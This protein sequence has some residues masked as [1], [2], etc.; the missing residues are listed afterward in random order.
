MFFTLRELFLYLLQSEV[1]QKRTHKEHIET[2]NQRLER[3]VNRY[4]ER[5]KHQEKIELLQ[6]KRPWAVSKFSNV[7]HYVFPKASN[8]Y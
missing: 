5:E 7:I 8:K 4:K 2:N 1:N 3:D 6:K